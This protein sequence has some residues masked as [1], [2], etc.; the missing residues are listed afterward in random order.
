MLLLWQRYSNKSHCP[1]LSVSLATKLH[2]PRLEFKHNIFTIVIR[3]KARKNPVNCD[4][5]STL[6]HIYSA[7]GF[8]F[9]EDGDSCHMEKI[10]DLFLF[11]AHG[12]ENPLFQCGVVCICVSQNTMFQRLSATGITGSC[13][14]T[15]LVNI[16][17]G[18]RF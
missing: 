18:K 17:E 15:Y 9:H 1:E 10:C 13:G 3:C 5:F 4:C 14:F 16:I 11:L 2:E 12:Y 8:E 6:G 7:R